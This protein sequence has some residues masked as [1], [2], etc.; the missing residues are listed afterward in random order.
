M[1]RDVAFEVKDLAAAEEFYG[2][3]MG[4]ELAERQGTT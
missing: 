1:N 2:G 3:V 4:F